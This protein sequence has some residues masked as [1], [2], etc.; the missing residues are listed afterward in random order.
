MLSQSSCF[1]RGLNIIHAG[2]EGRTDLP[3]NGGAVR[4]TAEMRE[5]DF[6][7]GEIWNMEFES[8]KSSTTMLSYRNT[9]QATNASPCLI[10]NFL[11][12]MNKK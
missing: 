9:V 10:L 11:I 1:K 6:V 3:E 5:E 4:R 2:E 12:V 8:E 7:A